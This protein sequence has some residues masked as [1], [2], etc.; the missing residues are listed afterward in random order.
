MKKP[1][2]HYRR[3]DSF[4][5]E[6][7]DMSVAAIGAFELLNAHAWHRWNPEQ[8][9]FPFLP[10]NDELLRTLCNRPRNW[11]RLRD[12]VLAKFTLE[13]GNWFYP[14]FR[15]DAQRLAGHHQR[16]ED[17]KKDRTA[18]KTVTKEERA[19]AKQKVEEQR[20]EMER[21]AINTLN[22]QAALTETEPA[23]SWDEAPAPEAGKLV[24]GL[25]GQRAVGWPNMNQ[26]LKHPTKLKETECLM[27]NVTDAGVRQYMVKVMKDG[28]GFA[29]RLPDGVTLKSE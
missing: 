13:D 7:Q 19:P 14:P 5:A 11:H 29:V 2:Y 26:L 18:K 16:K 4:L 12:E 8:H 23:R 15:E 10:N 20:E 28:R 9:P 24:Y 3:Y 27:W 22:G 21:K 1:N 17:K 6:T 25:Q